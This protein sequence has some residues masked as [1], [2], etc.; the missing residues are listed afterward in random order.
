MQP[1]W[2]IQLSY[3]LVY[4]FCCNHS[5]RCGFTCLLKSTK[6]I[7]QKTFVRTEQNLKCTVTEN[8]S[9]WKSWNKLTRRNK[10]NYRRHLKKNTK[11]YIAIIWQILALRNEIF[12]Q[13]LKNLSLIINFILILPITPTFSDHQNSIWFNIFHWASPNE[14]TPHCKRQCGLF[15]ML[16]NYQM[17]VYYI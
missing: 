11:F 6:T 10:N 17:T 15:G 2:K 8:A 14:K 5:A 4:S 1:I 3:F 12:L 13:K 7:L 9:W 16:C